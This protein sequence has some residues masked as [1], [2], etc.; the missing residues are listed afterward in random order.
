L[1]SGTSGQKA[2]YQSPSRW[3]SALIGKF[4][5]PIVTQFALFARSGK[6]GASRAPPQMF[7]ENQHGCVSTQP[8]EI[9]AVNPR[10]SVAKKLVCLGAVWSPR[11]PISPSLGSQTR[12]WLKTPDPLRSLRDLLLKNLSPHSPSPLP[13]KPLGAKTSCSAS[14]RPQW[15][16]ENLGCAGFSPLL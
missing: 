1:A 7:L 15:P 10:Q 11:R 4:T 3:I 13:V 5:I 9:Q 16:D 2:T 12:L 14:A 6:R 8:C